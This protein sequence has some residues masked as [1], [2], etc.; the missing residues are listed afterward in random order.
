M[1]NL[2]IGK[3]N[4]KENFLKI[5]ISSVDR[6]LAYWNITEEFD[7]IF[8]QKYGEDFLKKTKTM[9][10]LKNMSTGVEDRI[11]LTTYTNNYYI[12]YKYSNAVYMVELVKLGIEDEKDYGYKLVSNKIISPRITVGFKQFN[13]NNIKFKNI[14]DDTFVDINVLEK[15]KIE[16]LYS[17]QIIPAWSEYKAENGYRE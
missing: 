7:N 17:T 1:E 4:Y 14:K 8:K 9:L 10:I 12:K 2:E 15:E 6:I 3:Y 13:K 16:N 11:E 5:M